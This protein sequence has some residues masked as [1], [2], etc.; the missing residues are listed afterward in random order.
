[1]QGELG[2][3]PRLNWLGQEDI[4]P[5]IFVR[6]E[7]R[8]QEPGK[9]FSLDWFTSH[10]QP[11]Y[12]NPLCLDEVDFADQIIRLENAAFAGSGMPIPR[13][14]FYDCA[15]VP[16]FVAGFA[17]RKAS[18]PPE[19]V[20]ILKPQ[21]SSE[22]LPISLFI[23]IP[24]M[25]PKEWVAHNLCSVNSMLPDD[26]RYY[27]LGFLSKAFGLWYANIEIFS[28]ITQWRS[29]AI[30]LHT[31]YGDFEILTAYT[32]VHSHAQTLTYRVSVDTAEWK[33]F[34]SSE[35]AMG[36]H[37]R[38]VEAGF[39]IDPKDESSMRAFQRRLEEGKDKFFL[40]S[41]QIRTQDLD[42]PLKVYRRR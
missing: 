40:D 22:W 18:A 23:I 30:R 24:T 13:W 1:M 27:G 39:F 5:Y 16:G 29:P 11:L 6:P 28:G 14:V 41:N 31:H 9:R 42:A 19:I 32:P 3:F 2:R 25:A 21:E 35:Q 8:I 33:R 36:F 10:S 4:R 7:N 20:R 38:Y 17:I 15:I 26:K 37:E 34:F 12:K